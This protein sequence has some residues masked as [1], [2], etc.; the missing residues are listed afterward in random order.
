[1]EIVIPIV[2]G[3]I[4]FA[5]L[6]TWLVTRRKLGAAHPRSRRTK[7]ISIFHYSLSAILITFIVYYRLFVPGAD[8]MMVLTLFIGL[9]GEAGVAMLIALSV[10][11]QNAD[12][13]A[14]FKESLE[15]SVEAE[16]SLNR[17]FTFQE[18]NR[19]IYK[20]QCDAMGWVVVIVTLLSLP[21]FI[22]LLPTPVASEHM[23]RRTALISAIPAIIASGILYF[24]LSYI[25]WI[26]HQRK[27][28]P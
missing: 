8:G 3:L 28:K 18:W 17:S 26:I 13:D 25:T 12:N 23:S 27:F 10:W 2:I 11:S 6:I 21:L 7:N 5:P 16:N 4:F 22:Y 15:E 20:L 9:I 14:P 24:G 1:L 19:S